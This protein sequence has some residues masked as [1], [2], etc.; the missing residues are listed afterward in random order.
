MINVNFSGSY[1]N[2]GKTAHNLLSNLEIVSDA[3]QNPFVSCKCHV[4]TNAFA[5]YFSSVYFLLHQLT[6][7][8]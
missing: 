8:Q 5:S 1:E 4:A 6:V 2:I 7:S 3:L